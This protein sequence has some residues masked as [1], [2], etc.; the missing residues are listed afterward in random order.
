LLRAYA[1]TVSE[2]MLA[3]TTDTGT[4]EYNT[5]DAT[6]WFLHAIDR[7]IAATGDL[8]LAAALIPVL[9]GVIKAHVRG[10][11]TASASTRPTGYSPKVSMVMR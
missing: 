6:L 10:P 8:D 1:A 7:H 4:T 11:G 5:A 3:N 9:D 2:G